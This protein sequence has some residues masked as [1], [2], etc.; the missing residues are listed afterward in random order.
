MA[1]Y[2][3]KLNGY[4]YNGANQAYAALANGIFAEIGANGVVAITAAGDMELRVVEKTTL[5]GLPA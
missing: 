3:R 1:G 5:W 4:V 2:M